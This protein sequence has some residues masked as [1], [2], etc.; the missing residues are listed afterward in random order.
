MSERDQEHHMLC[1]RARRGCEYSKG[2]LSG[3]G[4]WRAR[5]HK[6]FLSCAK[7]WSEKGLH[8]AVDGLHTMTRELG[9]DDTLKRLQEVAE[10]YYGGHL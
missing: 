2:V 6:L 7:D 10:R 8:E 9:W 1:E 3:R 5:V 4:T